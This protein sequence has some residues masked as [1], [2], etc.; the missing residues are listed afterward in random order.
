MTRFPATLEAFLEMMSAERGAAA[1]TLAAYRRDLD[2]Y[3]GFLAGRNESQKAVVER[4]ETP[5]A[6]INGGAEPFVNNDFL[7]TIRYANLWEETIHLLDG[8]GHAPFWEVP[9]RFDPYLTRFLADV[10]GG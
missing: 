1:N 5:F 7:T 8:I 4:V 3:A 2:D 10:T 6:I 9:D